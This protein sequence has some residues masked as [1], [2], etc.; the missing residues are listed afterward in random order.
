MDVWWRH[1]R[2]QQIC[3]KLTTG[4]GV[5]AAREPLLI[6]VREGLNRTTDLW[7]KTTQSLFWWWQNSEINLNK[8]SQPKIYTV[9][10]S[11]LLE[12][13]TK[14]VF[15]HSLWFR[16][17]LIFIVSSVTCGLWGSAPLSCCWNRLG[18]MAP[19]IIATEQMDLANC[20]GLCWDAMLLLRRSR[21]IS[22]ST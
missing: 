19:D 4:A 21:R 9:L 13:K 15:T 16:T 3:C 5:E 2:R 8:W 20:R 11:E 6:T 14:L 10:T 7:S 22:K 18:H 12:P 1:N 17:L